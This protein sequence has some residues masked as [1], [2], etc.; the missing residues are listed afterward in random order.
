[1]FT[2]QYF[3]KA[4]FSY[5]G[6]FFKVVFSY[7]RVFSCEG[8]FFVQEYVFESGCWTIKIGIFNHMRLH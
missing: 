4:V 5:K 8:V 3:L 7:K 6:V 2:K 1:M